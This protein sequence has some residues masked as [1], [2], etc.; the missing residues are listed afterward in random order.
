MYLY[1][2]SCKVWIACNMDYSASNLSESSRLLRLW[3]LI[4]YCFT[5]RSRIFHLYGDVIITGTGLQNARRSG[6]L[7]RE[8][9]LPC[10]T[11]CDTG[12][13]FLRSHPKEWGIQSLLTTHEGMRTCGGSILTRILTGTDREETLSSPYDNYM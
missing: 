12:P 1:L 4:I 2:D 3:K 6:P 10:H 13:R 5:S 9:S 11:C 8:G 7:S